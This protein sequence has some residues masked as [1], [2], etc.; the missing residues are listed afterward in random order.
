M[1]EPLVQRVGRRGSCLL[2]FAV[3]DVLYALSLAKPPPEAKQSPT[4]AFISHIAPLDLWAAAWF[5]VG[6]ICFAGAFRRHDR[7]A[8]TAAVAIKTVWGGTF[9]LG[10]LL[11]GIDRGW[12]A[13][14]IWLAMAGW[15]YIISS[16]PEAAPKAA[17]TRTPPTV[18]P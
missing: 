14:V 11:A 13:A 15:V 16:W 3:L 4:V 18:T 6:V 10:W 9:L 5:T 2:F 8:F 7:W 1:P 17:P 12:V